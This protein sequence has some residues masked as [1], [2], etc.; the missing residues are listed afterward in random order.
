[1][2]I[3]GPKTVY[4][5]TYAGGA[6]TTCNLAPAGYAPRMNLVELTAIAALIAA[7]HSAT[8]TTDEHGG[9]IFNHPTDHGIVVEY[10]EPGGGNAVS[11]PVIDRKL[12]KDKNGTLLA[13]YHVHLCMAG[14][15]HQYFSVQDVVVAILSGVPEFMLD[16]CTG[17]IHEFDPMVD[18]VHDTGI[19]GHIA[20]PHCEDLP[21]HLPSGRVIGNIHEV[22]PEHVVPAADA[23]ACQS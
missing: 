7:K 5:G 21:R 20:G 22:E 16:E 17:D 9:M 19:D 6:K 18:R 12:L 8:G 11:V 13:T 4:S 2:P 3:E 10:I 15:Y 1:M 14:Y 23:V